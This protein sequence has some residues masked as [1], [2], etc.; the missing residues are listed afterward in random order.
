MTD[1][2]ERLDR[3]LPQ[4]QCGQCARPSPSGRGVGVR[5]RHAMQTKVPGPI[6]S[7]ATDPVGVDVLPNPHPALRA[8]FS[9]RE[10]ETS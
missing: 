6:L 3:L 7:R 5:V 1:L 4:T 9:P 8:T 10:K 2:I